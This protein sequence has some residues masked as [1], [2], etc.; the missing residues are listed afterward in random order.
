MKFQGILVL[1]AS[2]S[3][4]QD[5]IGKAIPRFGHLGRAELLQT[6]EGMYQTT[7]SCSQRSPGCFDSAADIT[8]RWCP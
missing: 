3:L 2:L 1:L 7:E 6:G 4:C 8:N 5:A